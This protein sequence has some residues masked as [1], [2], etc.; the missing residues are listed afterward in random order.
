M[1]NRYTLRRGLAPLLGLAGLDRPAEVAVLTWPVLWALWAAVPGTPPIWPVLLALVAWLLA[2]SAAT[3]LAQLWDPGPDPL[4]PPK[5]L[6]LGFGL[7]LGAGAVSALG[8]GTAWLPVLLGFAAAGGYP[9]LSHHSHLAQ[10]V[11]A[12]AYG[13]IAPAVF[14]LTG[15]GLSRQAWLLYAILSLWAAAYLTVQA[16]Q[17]RGRDAARGRKSTAQLFGDGTWGLLAALLGVM[18]LA[19]V[20]LG[21]EPRF[22]LPYHGAVAVAAVF[23]ALGVLVLRQDADAAPRATVFLNLAGAVIFLGMAVE[24]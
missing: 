15:T 10:L 22:G 6:A 12:L 17:R 14:L 1:S 8:E 7:I 11:L 3:V 19:L 18:F 21:G 5:L 23:G 13:V 4:P 20:L 9:L 2:R 24:A 16:L